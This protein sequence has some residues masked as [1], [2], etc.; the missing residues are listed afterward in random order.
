MTQNERHPLDD[1]TLDSAND[2]A[3]FAADEPQADSGT[4]KPLQVFTVY[5]IVVTAVLVVIS[6][7]I[8]GN[9]PAASPAS[10]LAGGLNRFFML[11]MLVEFALLLVSYRWKQLS[12]GLNSAT[13][14]LRIPASALPSS[15]PFSAIGDS[16]IAEEADSNGQPWQQPNDAILSATHAHA[17]GPQPSNVNLATIY[18]ANLIIVV[19]L[20]TLMLISPSFLLPWIVFGLSFLFLMSMGVF[21]TM[22]VLH[23]GPIRGYAIGFAAMA[24]SISLQFNGAIA[25]LYGY[26]MGTSWQTLALPFCICITLSALSGLTSAT[27]AA[28]VERRQM[29]ARLRR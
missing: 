12:R 18:A 10:Q 27:Y 17:P 1:D 29:V 19:V 22:A 15:S 25:G 7:T 8:A 3:I 4:N 2:D 21:I 24:A 14:G 16:T 26:P 20:W 11:A 5:A 9:A 6:G 28:I 13:E 23:S